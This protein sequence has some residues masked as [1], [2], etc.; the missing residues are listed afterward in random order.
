MGALGGEVSLRV[1]DVLG[2][3]AN[4]LVDASLFYRMR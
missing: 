4:Q 2:V 3:W 1:A